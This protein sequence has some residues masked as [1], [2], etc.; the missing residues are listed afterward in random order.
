MAGDVADGL[1]GHP[2]CPPRWLDE[3]V[4]PSFER[5]LSARG[6]SARISTSSPPSPARSTTTRRAPSTPRAGRSPSTRRFAPTSRCGRC[7]AS[8]SGGGRGR[9]LPQGRPGRR[10]RQQIPDEMVE[11][12]TPRA[13]WTRSASGSSEVA[14]RGDGVFLTPATYFI[15]P[16]QIGEY[17]ARDHR[18]LRAREPVAEAVDE[19]LELLA[20]RAAARRGRS[21]RAPAPARRAGAPTRRFRAGSGSEGGLRLVKPGD[22]R[23][24]VH[25]GEHVAQ[26]QHPVGLPP[27]GDVPG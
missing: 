24:L 18:G 11:A 1:I 7:T 16:E 23:V 17:Q 25:V 27:E 21:R 14:E 5:G 19:L 9:R 13:R 10:C 26:D 3:V 22:S 2:M 4:V 20:G 6:G 8:P 12:Y 15:P